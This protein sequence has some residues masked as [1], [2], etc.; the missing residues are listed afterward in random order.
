MFFSLSI[1]IC[2]PDPL[3]LNFSHVISYFIHSDTGCLLKITNCGFG[4]VMWWAIDIYWTNSPEWFSY[5]I[6]S[7]SQDELKYCVH[8]LNEQFYKDFL[9]RLVLNYENFRK[10][11]PDM[12]S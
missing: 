8:F 5:V 3:K 12:R 7:T 2:L 10:S 1:F 9:T 6:L 11:P 4:V